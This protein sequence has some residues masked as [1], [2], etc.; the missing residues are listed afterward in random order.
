MPNLMPGDILDEV[1]SVLLRAGRHVK[2]GRC[3]LTAYQILNRLPE[4]TRNRLVE[5]RQAGGKTPKCTTLLQVSSR[6]RQSG[7]L[8]LRLAG[9]TQ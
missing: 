5:E 9:S 7:C 3:F 8:V 4:A 1:R 6:T 2:F